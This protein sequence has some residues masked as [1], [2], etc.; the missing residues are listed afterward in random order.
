MPQPICGAAGQTSGTLNTLIRSAGTADEF[1][2]AF[3][4]AAHSALITSVVMYIFI[5]FSSEFIG[6]QGFLFVRQ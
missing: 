2:A 6:S 3:A 4:S 5:L 1:S